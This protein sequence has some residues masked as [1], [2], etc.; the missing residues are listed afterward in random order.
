VKKVIEFDEKCPSC[1][2][3]GLYVG[4]GEH[5]GA[6]VVCHK[7]NGTG[8]HRFVHEFEEFSTLKERPGI[9]RVYQTNPGIGIGEGNGHQLEDF[10]G[11]PV[12]EWAEGRPFIPGMEMRRF[13]CPAWWYQ[14][15]D[16][17]LKPEWPEC[18]KTLGNPFSRCPNF[19][20]KV[21][22]WERWDTEKGGGR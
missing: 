13:T 1:D 21:Q 18:S 4:M 19:P 3:T 20:M 11:M 10:G 5:S 2:G 7:C 22:C 9:K 12:A 14:S 15:A 17:K 6:A 16:Y 8:C